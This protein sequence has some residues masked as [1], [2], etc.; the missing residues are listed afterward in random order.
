MYCNNFPPFILK[1]TRSIPIP[2]THFV[3]KKNQRL[4]CSVKILISR[5]RVFW[6]RKMEPGNDS[7]GRVSGYQGTQVLGTALMHCT[8]ALYVQSSTVVPLSWL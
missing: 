6:N 7:F 4:K 2:H 1:M 5:L 8:Y 3:Y